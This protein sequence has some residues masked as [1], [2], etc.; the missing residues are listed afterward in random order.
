MTGIYQITNKINSKKYIGFSIDIDTRWKQHIR[1][2]KNN[3]HPNIKLQNAWNKYGEECFEFSVVEECSWNDCPQAE[4][5]WIDFYNTYENGY[6]LTRGGDKG[7]SEYLEKPIYVYTTNGNY[8]CCFNSRA[9]AQRVLDCYS[10]KECLYGKCIKGF[11]KTYNEW[12][13]FSFK[14]EDIGSC[15]QKI[16]PKS[17]KVFKL[18]ENGEIL[19]EYNSAADVYR[20][21]NMDVRRHNLRDAINEHSIWQGSYWSYADIYDKETWKPKDTN[22]IVAYLNGVEVG[23]FKNA[24]QAGKQLKCDNSS[25]SKA[26]KGQKK[27][28]NGFTFKKL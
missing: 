20:S 14:K 15:R 12:F 18:D 4:I 17:K 3:T 28:V 2:L 9:E 7:C 26:L 25:I 8:F 19:E 5:K 27:T 13:Q 24:T 22:T 21:F 10:I 23:R 11:S 16:N 1:K 6:N